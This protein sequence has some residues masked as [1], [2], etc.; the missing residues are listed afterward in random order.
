MITSGKS[1]RPQKKMSQIQSNKMPILQKKARKK[2]YLIVF[3]RLRAKLRANPTTTKDLAKEQ[4][5]D[6]FNYNKPTCARFIY[7]QKRKD[8]FC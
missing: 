3:G 1:R 2:T 5:K 4:P 6:E 7:E 8:I